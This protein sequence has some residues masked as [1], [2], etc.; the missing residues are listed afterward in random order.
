MSN[1]SRNHERPVP[2]RHRAAD[3]RRHRPLHAAA[4]DGALAGRL[5]ECVRPPSADHRHRRAHGGPARRPDRRRPHRDRAGAGAAAGDSRHRC[6]PARCPRARP[7]A[8]HRQ[9]HRRARSGTGRALDR[10]AIAAA[11][12]GRLPAGRRHRQPGATAALPVRPAAD[13]R[14]RLPAARGAARTRHL[15]PGAGR[16]RR[17]GRLGRHPQ[18][19]VAHRRHHLLSR[20]LAV[21]Q[22]PLHRPA[23]RCAGRAA[24]QRLAGLHRLAAHAGRERHAGRPGLLRR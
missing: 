14:L 7:G 6:A 23:G 10:A 11:G 18:P 15:P 5:R 8:G 22:H 20:A 19:G 3:P 1:R 9:R 12:G 17:A 2:R 21:R 13:D 16:T 24:A 4:G